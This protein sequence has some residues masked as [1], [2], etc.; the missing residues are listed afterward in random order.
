IWTIPAFISLLY[1]YLKN[2]VNHKK[3]YK[4][5][6]WWTILSLVLL[7]IIPEKK[8]RYL[9]PVLIPLALNTG[10][11]LKYILTNF[12]T[13][14][15]TNEK[16]PIYFH[17]GLIGIIGIAFPVAGYFILDGK[18]GPFMFYYITSSLA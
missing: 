13:T 12:K 17:F 2:R 4:L 16:I 9:V 15:T 14:L 8:A 11:Y 7:S 5:T 1:P 3:A 6:F 18:I 10:I